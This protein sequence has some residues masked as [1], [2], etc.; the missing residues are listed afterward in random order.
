MPPYV[1]DYN[2]S[3]T[4][5]HRFTTVNASGVPTTLGNTPSA[6]YYV[7][8]G[9]TAF[10][11]GLT[12]TADFNSKTGLNSLAVIC[13]SS[14][15][16]LTSGV[17]VSVQVAAGTVSAVSLVGYPIIEYSITRRSPL[18]PAT[19]NRT[20][21]ISSTGYAA[22]DW[23]AIGT[24]GATNDLSATTLFTAT[25]VTNN[26]GAIVTAVNTITPARITAQGIDVG[27]IVTT[28]NT[29]TPARITAQGIDVGAIVTAI[30]TN[31]GAIVTAVNTITP[32]RVTAQGIDVGAI[33]TASNTIV[34]ARITAQG[35]DIGAIV[36]AVNTIVPARITAQGIDIGA[37]VTASN[38]IVAASVT[39]ISASGLADLFL[40]DSG[41]T[42]ASAVA[43]SPVKEIA[44]N[45][46]G[47]SLSVTAIA[48]GVWD[49]DATENQA[50]GSFGQ[51]LGDSTTNTSL[52][53]QVG[54]AGSGL[55]AIPLV[56]ANVTTFSTILPARITAQGID[57]G[58]I[59]TAV[60]TIVPA[61]VTAQ[62]IDIGAI[63]TA[64]NTIA[65]ANV[66]A[67]SASGLA[68]L[69]LTDSGTTYASAVAGS[70]VKEIADNAG[71]TSLTVTGI[72][73]GVWDKDATENQVQGSFGQTLGD[74][75][76]N[77]SLYI[78]VG[79]A[80]S[81]LTA[82]PLVNANVTAFSTIVAAR[83]TAQG[84]DVGAIVTAV[85]TIVP[86]RITAQGIDIG[87]IV[88]AVNTITPA[89]VTAQGIDVGA[90][91]TA[92]NTIA[93]ARVTSMAASGLASLFL[94][95]SGTTYASSVAG[96]PV[97]EIADNAGGTSLTVTGIAAGVWDEILTGATHNI[98]TSAGR[99]LRILS[100]ATEAFSGTITGTPS[101]TV[102]RLS[103]SPSATDNFY[104]PGLVVVE[105]SFGTQFRRISSYDGT[106]NDVTVSSAFETVPVSGDPVT[107]IPW[108]SVR[109]SEI[110]AGVEVDANVEKINGVTIVGDG[111]TT[112]FNV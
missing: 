62:G 23:A 91:V 76:T 49:K 98:P 11:A 93:A 66:T 65:D 71:G 27:A 73:S 16:G 34:A 8:G 75:T 50:Q 78:Q 95:D 111:S 101:T 103:G 79:V 1:G 68:H 53:I 37:I 77:T 32:A 13:T 19:A 85:N 29:I 38:T 10:T 30:N 46:G 5:H 89:R 3:T 40:T 94:T 74:S 109:V 67:F 18:R 4:F 33:V 44:D 58:A 12:L 15:T 60:N 102:I 25:N 57:I 28:V 108:A 63:V 39:S 21:L 51:T 88:T 6:E 72:A 55:T 110:D 31:V 24:P 47:A 92:I 97:K 43:G 42:Y 26:V 80:G 112:P 41:T 69:F 48:S 56:N 61:R 35:I 105:S 59:V 2:L 82:I 104:R 45:A 54:V 81:G 14:A 52:Y 17:N 90:I 36:T 100:G 96:S 107:I 9:T 64:I 22:I 7:D 84:I 86:A 106:T 83:I 87:A 20:V 99:R 70:P